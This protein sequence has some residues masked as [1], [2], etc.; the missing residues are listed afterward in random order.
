ML[1]DAKVYIATDVKLVAYEFHQEGLDLFLTGCMRRRN[2]R[3]LEADGKPVYV[4]TWPYSLE[5]PRP[6]EQGQE[7][8]FTELGGLEGFDALDGGEDEG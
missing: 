8:P 4:A 1:F 5:D 3:R 6:F 7:D 2:E